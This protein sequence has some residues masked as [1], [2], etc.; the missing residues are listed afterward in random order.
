MKSRIR[1]LLWL[2]LIH[3]KAPFARFGRS[4]VAGVPARL[5]RP[6]VINSGATPWNVAGV[7]ALSDVAGVSA[8]R[9]GQ[10]LLLA[11]L[12]MLLAAL[13]GA[14]FLAVVSGNLN[15]SARVA[16]KTRAIEA[17]R[18]GIAYANAQLSGSAQGDLWRPIDVSP[19][20]D[21]TDLAYDF[22]YSQ[23]EK[24]QGWAAPSRPSRA[25]FAD[26]ATYRLARKFYRD[27]TYGKFPDPNQV[28]GDA[29]KFLVKVEE[30]AANSPTE[31]SHVGEIKITSIGLSQDDPNVFHRSIAYKSG[32]LKSPWASALRGVSNWRFGDTDK[33]SGVPYAT[34]PRIVNAGT[35]FPANNVEFTVDTTDKPAFSGENVPFNVVIVKKDAAPSV[36]GAVI[37]KVENDGAKLTFARLERTIGVGETIQKAAALGI[38]AGIDLL[39]T[40]RPAA[41][42]KD[43]PQPGGITA[44][45]SVWLQGQILLS[46]L[47]K[48][49][50]QLKASGSLAI[51]GADADKKQIA[52]NSGDIGPTNALDATSNRIVA[53]S[54]NNFP[55]NLILTAAARSNGVETT[56]LVNDGWNRIGAR[57]LGL[58]YSSGRAIEPFVP[59]KIDSPENLARYYALTRGSP[60]GIYIDNRG[61]FERV[62]GRAMTQAELVE[63]LIS[64]AT[65]A[66]FQDVSRLGVAALPGA[67]N[68]SLEQRHLRGWIGADEFLARGALI[69][70]IQEP[71][72]EPQVRVT[73]DARNDADP[74]GPAASQTF[75]DDNGQ[76]QRGVYARTFDWPRNGTILAEGNLRVRGNINLSQLPVGSDAALFPSLTIVSL[77]NIYIEG[78]LS[79]DS[80]SAPNSPIPLLQRKK[81]LLLAR[82]NVI[83]NPTRAV[84]ART[85]AQTVATNSA[86]VKLNGTLDAPKSFVIAVADALSF[87]KGDLAEITG[88]A[89]PTVIRG[90]VTKADDKNNLLTIISPAA[91]LIPIANAAA[92]TFVRS[93]LEK[94]AAGL[95][96]SAREYFSLVDTDNAINRRIVAPLTQDRP[97]NR[98]R[99]VF[100]HGGDLKADPTARVGLKIRAEDFDVA[101]PRPADF[102]AV[103]TNKQPLKPN[104]NLDLVPTDVRQVDKILRTRQNFAAPALKEFNGFVTATKAKPLSQ[105]AL[106]IRATADS[107]ETPQ[108]EGYRYSADP[109][110]AAL[111]NLPAH[112]LMGIGLRYET[113]AVFVA[114]TESLNNQRREDF[115]GRT[116]PEGFI[117]PLATS[118]E[119]DLNGELTNLLTSSQSRK[120][121]YIGFNPKVV[122]SDDGLTVGISFY[123][124]LTNV[125]RSSLDSRALEIEP[126]INPDF[127]DFPQSIVFKRSIAVSTPATS[128]L[129]PDYRVRSLKIENV[130]LNDQSIKPVMRALPINAFVCAQRG[131]WLV[132]PGDFFRSTPP[133]RGIADNT[134]KIIGSYIDFDNS[135]TIG[136]NEYILRDPGDPNSAKIAD[137]NRDGNYDKGEIEA[138]LR[139]ARTNIAPIQFTG[140]IIENQSAIVSDVAAVT[141]GAPPVVVGAV[142]DW[143]D[144]W[145][146]YNDVGAPNTEPGKPYLFDFIS[147]AFDPSLA[148]GSAGADELRV[149]VTNALL[150]QQ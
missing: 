136:A 113:G 89:I 137:L 145:A 122:D 33:N 35:Q 70:L 3:R 14:G 2:P 124:P 71:D 149:P 32:R 147:Y 53:S 58:D 45:G 68:V 25:D 141:V 131:S 111:A 135:K 129:L 34:L 51:D 116:A 102:T 67:T 28:A 127:T 50:S 75:R 59:V 148:Q 108:P 142:Q 118:V 16:D 88:A 114:P 57:A 139:F 87:N 27:S 109:T 12:I 54:Q 20:P 29:P 107:R 98:N 11:V 8:R 42:P 132:I 73:L 60:G 41:Y 91:G 48:N 17:S 43:L 143:T 130:S 117:I 84:L 79:V 72:S 5:A 40:G 7:P 103:L 104:G 83:V 119:Y 82:K 44:N 4:D 18:A 115:D 128:N 15:Q 24:V 36:R 55:G 69:E 64:P 66:T 63:M 100:D 31:S 134:G 46:N 1:R 26:E 76:L 110:D 138:G 9:R 97:T 146:T 144:K 86:T 92:P 77:G 105:F 47:S 78:A 10:A 96:V 38:G 121:K 19:A 56:D 106:E 150:Y 112:A 126:A 95:G 120:T 21:T 85:D 23:L 6:E 65:A 90:L 125:A 133:V 81:L 99:L 13:L 123:Q 52:Q 140:A 49:G 93:P 80:E 94:R 30:I 39:N 22:Y 37:T 74:N 62:D 101:H 61:D